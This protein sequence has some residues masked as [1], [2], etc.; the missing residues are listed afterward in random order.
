MMHDIIVFENLQRVFKNL[1][2]GEK[3]LFRTGGKQISVFKLKR[4]RVDGA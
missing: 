2:S 3:I 1:H 4:I